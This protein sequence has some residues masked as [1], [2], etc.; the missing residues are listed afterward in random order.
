MSESLGASALTWLRSDVRRF[1]F[2]VAV[3][4]VCLSL[5]LSYGTPDPFDSGWPDV[6]AAAV[7]FVLL[8]LRSRW[9]CLLLGVSAAATVAFVLVYQRPTVLVFAGLV[10][11]STVCVGL[12]R[13]R[14]FGLGAVSALGL[15]VVG[16]SLSDADEFGDARAVIFIV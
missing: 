15:Y 5:A 9:P 6:V 14:A 7:A 13:W 3:A 4:V 8:A 16:L 11:L 12:E 1:D 10:L 2:V